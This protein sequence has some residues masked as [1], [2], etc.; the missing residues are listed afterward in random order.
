MSAEELKKL[1]Q[2]ATIK[3]DGAKKGEKIQ[4]VVFKLGS[5]EYALSIDHIKEVVITPNISMMPKTPS[6]IKGVANI[7]GSVIAIIDLEDKFSLKSIG[8]EKEFNY[9][10]VIESDEYSVGILVNEVP[11]TLNT[12][13]SMI[14]TTSN[15]MQFSSLDE[16][17]ISGIVKDEEKM[18]ILIDIIKMVE[19]EDIGVK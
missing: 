15:V 3:D 16:D 8:H 5:E 10:L 14:D 18:I 12:S 19:K 11:N 1:S 17:C 6:Y 4:L 2:K 9:T 7:R 13:T